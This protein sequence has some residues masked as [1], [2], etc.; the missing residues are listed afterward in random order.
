MSRA[1]LGG[2]VLYP[3]FV[4]CMAEAILIVVGSGGH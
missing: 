3:T 2:M 1:C 4:L